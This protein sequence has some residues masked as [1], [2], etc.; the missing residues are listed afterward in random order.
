[1]L[2]KEKRFKS[3]FYFLITLILTLGL[4]ISL[5]SLLAAW[6]GP[7]A[8]PPTCP[9]GSPGCDA[10]INVGSTAQIKA[11]NIGI[12]VGLAIPNSLLHVYQ[13]SGN[14]AEIDLQSVAG[15]S[16]HWGIYNDRTTN[17]LQIGRAHV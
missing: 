3:F 14:N 8:S 15:A 7:T 4:S 9:A 11:G 12:G 17:D 16:N 1:M 13:T 2:N 10:P 6:T 5:Q